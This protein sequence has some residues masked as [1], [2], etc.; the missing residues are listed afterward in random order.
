LQRER[1]FKKGGRG[2]D[3]I[4]YSNTTTALVNQELE[5]QKGSTAAGEAGQDLLPAGLLLVCLGGG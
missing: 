5:I 3:G 2:W 4:T 1:G